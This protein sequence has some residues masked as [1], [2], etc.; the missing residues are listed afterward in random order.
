MAP[1]LRGAPAD[2]LAAFLDSSTTLVELEALP[3]LPDLCPY[4]PLYSLAPEKTWD[5]QNTAAANPSF[6][7]LHMRSL[8][9]DCCLERA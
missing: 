4:R 8:H 9:T 7:S 6:R 1:L 5:M 2:E 3:E